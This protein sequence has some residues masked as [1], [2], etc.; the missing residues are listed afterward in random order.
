MHM[1][2]MR[3]ERPR[4]TA[5]S[6]SADAPAAGNRSDE[7]EFGIFGSAEQC[8]VGTICHLTTSLALDNYTH[9]Q[10]VV[11]NVTT[12][13]HQTPYSRESTQENTQPYIY[14]R[15]RTYI[16]SVANEDECVMCVRW[17]VG[18]RFCMRDLRKH[19]VSADWGVCM[20]CAMCNVSA[21][22]ADSRERAWVQWN[23]WVK[24]VLE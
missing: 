24:F 12:H 10:S 19:K 6:A 15:E 20:Q 1:Q 3:F 22:N 21:T 8:S 18:G 23:K 7:M 17:I 5:A 9:P 13:I 14:K 2:F 11:D 16:P 4:K